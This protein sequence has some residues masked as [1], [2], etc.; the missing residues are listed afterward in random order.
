MKWFWPEPSD[1]LSVRIGRVLHWLSFC[2]CGIGLAILLIAMIFGNAAAYPDQTIPFA[3]S[4]IGIAMLGRGLRYV[5][6]NE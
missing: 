5:L 3:L 4:C 2:V 1:V 6:A